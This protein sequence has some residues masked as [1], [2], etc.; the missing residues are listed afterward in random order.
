[1]LC[2]NREPQTMVS[3]SSTTG[4][5]RQHDQPPLPFDGQFY[6]P[7]PR[8]CQC[9]DKKPAVQFVSWTRANPM[10]R[11]TVCP[12]RFSNP[13]GKC[14]LY[15]W[16][17]PDFSEF[18]KKTMQKLREKIISLE[19]EVSRLEAEVAHMDELA[20]NV[21][22]L[23]EIVAEKDLLLQGKNDLLDKLQEEVKVKKTEICCFPMQLLYFSSVILLA[24]WCYPFVASV[25]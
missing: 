14:E 3:T 6:N 4:S 10:R 19:N 9:V 11:F 20:T 25:E 12:L 5:S 16:N 1:M 22:K 2:R 15:Q 17:D 23:R 21:A 13:N 18:Q 7:T 8:H 24:C